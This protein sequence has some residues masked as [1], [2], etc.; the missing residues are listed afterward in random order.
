MASL[1]S[2][3]KVGREFY[4]SVFRTVA[5]PM[6]LGYACHL[7]FGLFTPA[8]SSGESIGEVDTVRMRSLKIRDSRIFIRHLPASSSVIAG[9]WEPLAD[10]FVAIFQGLRASQIDR[11]ALLT[12][13]VESKKRGSRGHVPNPLLSQI[14]RRGP[15]PQPPKLRPH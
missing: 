5:Y 1:L 10:T 3:Q 4:R 6:C 12:R 8:S 2:D 11:L 14:L 9:I 13:Q 15:F 7:S